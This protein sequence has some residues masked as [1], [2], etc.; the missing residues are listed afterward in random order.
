MSIVVLWFF[1]PFPF[2][3]MHENNQESQPCFGPV[4]ISQRDV[5]Y[6]KK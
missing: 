3:L 5:E 6:T 2:V 4:D 1:F